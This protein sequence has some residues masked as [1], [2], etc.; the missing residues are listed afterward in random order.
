MTGVL[1]GRTFLAVLI[2]YAVGAI[3]SLLCYR[4]AALS[5]RVACASAGVGGLLA[6]VVGVV[7]L[8]SGNDVA[9]SSCL[10]EIERIW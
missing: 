7:C 9:S 8:I 1:L 6:T 4:K 10:S 2:S 3:G 5:R